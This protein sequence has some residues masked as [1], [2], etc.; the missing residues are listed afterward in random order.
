MSPERSGAHPVSVRRAQFSWSQSELASRAGL[1]RTTICAIEGQR[2][3]PSVATALRLARTL[4][5]TVEELFGPT[6]DSSASAPKWAW[7][8]PRERSRYWMAE[9]GGRTWLYP[10]EA[11]S[12]N[13]I[14]H[15]GLCR[16]RV[17]A[18]LRRKIPEPTLVLACCDPAAGLLA[19]EYA[20]TSGFRM[21]VLSRSSGAAVDLLARGLVH[22]AGLHQST[23]SDPDRNSQI[24][25]QRLGNS[26]CLIRATHW[27]EGLAIPSGRTSRN[28]TSVVRDAR[29]WALREEGS[30]AHDCLEGLLE[31]AK[32]R[33]RAVWGHSGVVEAVRSGWA[34]A[35]VCVRLPAEEAGLNFL[36]VRTE[37]LDFC[38]WE[39]QAGDPRVL[40]LIRLLRSK[41]YRQLLSELPGY[42]A[43]ETG[44][45]LPS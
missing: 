26:V 6:K 19:T 28:V 34:D 32:P 5:C 40:A 11:I 14:P 12:V 35:G 37:M 42:D 38:Y 45:S 8:P 39:S 22:V 43:R 9:V 44:E 23:A 4:E 33:G 1:P 16:P 10:V 25:G 15:E 24:V 3:T 17:A 30:A 18:E 13:G 36:S 31:G 27:E 21:I 29:R 41:D 2:L 20:R 7:Q